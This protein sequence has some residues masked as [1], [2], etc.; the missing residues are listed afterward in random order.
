MGDCFVFLPFN[1]WPIQMLFISYLT[2]LGQSAKHVLPRL[3]TLP[4]FL[5][6]NSSSQHVNSSGLEIEKYL[7]KEM[8]V[9]LPC[10]RPV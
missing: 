4:E 10:T 1:L 9:L 7:L 2:P 6:E 8:T 3:L 5:M